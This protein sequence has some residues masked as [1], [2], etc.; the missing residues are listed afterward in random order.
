VKHLGCEDILA[1]RGNAWALEILVYI[2]NYEVF[3]METQR[4]I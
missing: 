2:E 4:R 3:K 1:A